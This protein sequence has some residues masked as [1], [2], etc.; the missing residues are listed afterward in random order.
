VLLYIWC[1]YNFAVASF[2]WGLAHHH[3]VTS[4]TML[5]VWLA[6]CSTSSLWCYHYD[7]ICW[8]AF[9]MLQVP[10]L[11]CTHSEGCMQSQHQS[12]PSFDCGSRTV[13]RKQCH[14]D[15]LPMD[16]QS[17]IQRH[18]PFHV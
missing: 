5:A 4:K 14:R 9:C 13:H 15:F 8:P 1:Y 17:C 10:P 3:D 2:L 11:W 18:L 16:S 6:V 12:A 7:H